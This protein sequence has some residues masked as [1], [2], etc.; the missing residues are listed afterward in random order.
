MAAMNWDRIEGNWKQCTGSVREKWGRLTH[1][2]LE[3]IGGKRDALA[4]KIQEI[5]GL[6]RE[7]AERQIS[8]WQETMK[9]TTEETK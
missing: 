5:Y 8:E 1:D 3:T 6:T 9:Q 7:A 4:G 2:Q